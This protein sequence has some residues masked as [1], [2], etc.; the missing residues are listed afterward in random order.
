VLSPDLV[1][2]D[3]FQSVAHLAQ[4]VVRVAGD[5]LGVEHEYVEVVLVVVDYEVTPQSE[6][7]WL[8]QTDT[9][10]KVAGRHVVLALQVDFAD[11]RSFALTG[12]RFL[13]QRL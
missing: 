13:V 3:L 1:H 7:T 8:R 9:L 6:C 10:S 12:P 2:V 5:A 11:S 4:G